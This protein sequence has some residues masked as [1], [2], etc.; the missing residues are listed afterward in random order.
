[1]RGR[2]ATHLL[3]WSLTITAACGDQTAPPSC[4]AA[5]ASQIA[6]AVGADT[7]ID[8]ASDGGC[9]TFAANASTI[10]SAEYLVVPQST[11]GAP[12]RSAPFSLLSV[13]P[14]PSAPA[15]VAARTRASPT[16]VAVAFDQSLRALGRAHAAMGSL[17]KF[18]GIRRLPNW[19]R[20]SM[21]LQPTRR[22]SR[23]S[24]DGS[25]DC[26][27]NSCGSSR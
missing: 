12:G 21:R 10:D 1:M 3:L 20:N 19:S 24:C 9:V 27:R 25:P 23:S 5:L 18:R 22:S 4:S 6:L 16:P 26:E 17:R 2:V 8:P 7:S 14:T 15:P 11:G 13:T